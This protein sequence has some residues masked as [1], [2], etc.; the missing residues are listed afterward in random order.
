MKWNDFYGHK[1]N[2]KLSIKSRQREYNI[3]IV[4]LPSELLATFIKLSITS[5]ENFKFIVFSGAVF[6]QMSV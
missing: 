2:C 1:D 6:V 5:C 4:E 3:H